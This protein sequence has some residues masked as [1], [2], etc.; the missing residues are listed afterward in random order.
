M[1][2]ST[3][4]LA[5]DLLPPPLPEPVAETSCIYFRVDGGASF[6][7]RP[8]VYKNHGGKKS[9]AYG[10]KLKDSGFIEGGVGCQFTPMFRA[11]I[12][13]GYRFDSKLEDK[14]NSLDAKLSTGTIFANGYVDFD[15]FGFVKPYVGGGVGVAFHSISNVD[16]PPFSSSGSSTDFAWNVQAGLAFDVTENIAVDVGY[17]YVDLGDAKSGGPDH[18]HVDSITAHEARVGLRFRLN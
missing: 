10:E 14:W 11:D 6:H 17:R 16:K 1:S 5:A 2:A 13:G 15:Y 7:E 4:A 12:V 9:K 3:A 8:N 18:F